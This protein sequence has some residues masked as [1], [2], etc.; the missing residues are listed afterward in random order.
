MAMRK[1]FIVYSSKFI[2]IS[3][4]FTLIETL[5]TVLIFA[6]LATLATV[7]LYSLLRGAAKA[8]RIKELKQNGDYALSVMELKIRNSQ[9]DSANCT[10]VA[11]TSLT[12][13]MPDSI[14]TQVEYAC[15]ANQ[16]R[17]RQVGSTP[18]Q[19][20]PQPS[21]LTNTNV[22]VPSCTTADFSITCTIETTGQK[23]VSISYRLTQAD[24][25]L[26]FSEAVS[27]RFQTLVTLRNK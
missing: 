10:G 20:S 18:P 9:I 15:N 11:A 21:Y 7:S 2:V 17:E 19:S 14:Q 1:K 22:A 13:Q 26:P 12:I 8:E 24:D 27:E 23:T 4:G 25:T 16:I 3:S 6:V 5:V